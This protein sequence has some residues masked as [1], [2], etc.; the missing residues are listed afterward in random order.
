M[1]TKRKLRRALLGCGILLAVAFVALWLAGPEPVEMGPYVQNVTQTSADVCA[2]DES[3][4]R[5]KVVVEGSEGEITV[6]E[7]EPVSAH[8][9]S[10]RNLAPGTTYA[11]RILAAA[12]GVQRWAGEFATAPRDAAKPFTFVVVGDSGDVPNW[13]KLHR[14]GWGRMRGALQYTERT[15]Q[16]DVAEWIAKSAPDFFVHLGDIIYT[17]NQLPGYEEAFFR[18]FGPVLRRCPL[19]ATFGNHD[20]HTWK[21]PEFFRIFH[22]PQPLDPAKEYS[23]F[24]H[25]FTW[26]GVQFLVLDCFWQEWGTD[27]ETSKWLDRTL[28]ESRFSRKIVV[29]H[30][31]CYSDE[32]NATEHVEV[33]RRLW[34]VFAR[35]RVDLVIAG[36]SHNYQRF[37]PIDGVLQVIV[38]TGGRSIRPVARSDRLHHAEER[39]GFLLVRVT[40]NRIEGEF[41]TGAV[42]PLDRFVIQ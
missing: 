39:F 12:T 15:A 19:V 8:V 27:G 16:W 32:R 37:K 23:D 11:Y 26:A 31:P 2:F 24:S 1:N 7:D 40:G 5:V 29:M 38:G 34:P 6:A 33:R 9:L 3:P 36:D 35:H 14:F 22:T 17:H 10:V 28:R 21:H 30:S 13:F 4:T 42:E 20:M 41:R 25:A 18:P